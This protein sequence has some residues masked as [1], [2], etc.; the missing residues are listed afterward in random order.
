MLALLALL[1]LAPAELP[2]ALERLVLVAP[3]S[4]D[5]PEAAA[6]FLRHER[7][8]EVDPDG[9]VELTLR[10]TIKILREEGRRHRVVYLPWVTPYQS[11]TVRAA[12]TVL[13]DLKL[14]D[15]TE[16][17][18]E[19]LLPGGF[20]ERQ[21]DMARYRLSF[22]YVEPGAVVDYE[23]VIADS[24]PSMPGSFADSF[25]L[26][27]DDPVLTARYV[28]R[29][30]AT[31]AFERHV[32]GEL[33]P[34][35]VTRRGSWAETTWLAEN[36]PG[37]T[38]EPERPDDARLLVTVTV[39]S[40]RSWDEVA[41]RYRELA[42]PQY[43]APASLR[44]EAL[45]L[46]AG[47]PD[48]ARVLYELVASQ[49]RYAFGTLE[50]GMPGIQPRPAYETWRQRLGDCKDQATLL[51]TLLREAGLTAW[52]ALLRRR[53]FG[54]VAEALPAM[55]QFDHVIVAVPSGGG[56]WR[57]F[58]PTW[59]FGPHDY[60]PNDLQGVR[61]LVITDRDWQ[62]ATLPTMPASANVLQREGEFTL[63]E[64]GTLTG[65]VTVR[66]SGGF[67]QALRSRFHGLS[68]EAA[69]REV[70]LGLNATLARVRFDPADL[71][72]SA[73]ES[74][75]EPFAMTYRLTA[76]G[77]ALRTRDLLLVPMA[78]LERAELPAG[79]AVARRRYPLGLARSP[80]RTI[81]QLR[82]R[83][84]PSLA[85]RELPENRERVEPFG[86]FRVTFR[87]DGDNLIYRR[88]VTLP[89]PEVPAELAERVR[90]WY[91]ELL[92]ADQQLL[93]LERRPAP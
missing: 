33:P 67:E 57:W 12:R 51:I 31:V 42:L 69:A 90:A 21:G 79:L 65:S 86:S 59:S 28:V 2:P 8:F 93:V 15:V 43:V 84:P 81:N 16:V 62:W 72:L 74:L 56:R 92:A 17:A 20:G 61:A 38:D 18:L 25:A 60:L 45:K 48:P 14:V 44:E 71:Q 32:Q 40:S 19:R 77:Y 22:P 35:T 3:R 1:A 49:V 63:G 39:S 30:P 52:P 54:P 75:V 50:R 91:A 87:H 13:P 85:V 80:E 34:P 46:T 4:E 24:R 53:P 64:D 9:R 7:V 41:A 27:R 58:D 76:E 66:A 70:A 55:L 47:H 73:V 36:L 11:V 78:V 29:A 26:Q 10:A 88:E 82:F 37:I 89:Q 5:L 83:L 68:R 6:V 23:V